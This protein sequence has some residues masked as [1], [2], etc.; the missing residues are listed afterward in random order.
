MKPATMILVALNVIAFVWEVASGTD[1]ND[2]YSLI[3]HGAL[4]GSLVIGQHEWWRI[5]TCAFMHGGLVHLALNMFALLQLGT[6]VESVLG[7]WRM[8]AIYMISLFGGGL[9]VTYF[10]PDNP[11]V[12]ASGAIFGLFGALVAIGLRLGP[13]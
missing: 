6:F 13:R 5:V 8:A 4:V 3:A 1:L 2:N 10:N 7:S 11:T 9:A 12:G